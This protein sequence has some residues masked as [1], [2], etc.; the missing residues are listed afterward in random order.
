[1]SF[2]G[3]RGCAANTSMLKRRGR[4]RPGPLA[5][6]TLAGALSLAL[7]GVAITP[8]QAA[9]TS[10]STDALATVGTLDH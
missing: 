2:E 9:I 4:R 7:M 6:V 3:I 1:M 8:A 5:K 10:S